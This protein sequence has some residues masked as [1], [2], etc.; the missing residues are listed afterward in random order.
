MIG[1]VAWLDAKLYPGI[2]ANWD[3]RLFR[4]RIS[5]YLQQAPKDV[6][7]LGAGAGI[8]EQMN[9]RGMA[10]RICGL[11]PD[12]RVKTNPFLDEGK[13]GVGESV[14][15]SDESFDVVFADNVLE[16]LREP[17]KVFREVMRVLRPGGV[18]LVKTPN[19]WHYMPLVARLTPHKFHQW[20]NGKRG[21]Q[22][23]DI[24]PTI[25]LANTPKKIRNLAASVGL[26]IRNLDLVESRP[27][28]LRF[29]VPTYIFGWI[30]DLLVNTLP[31]L[32]RF[33]ILIIAELQKPA[34]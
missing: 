22:Q 29:S 28:Y 31:V 6:L 1:S 17:E 16:H 15:Y 18:F 9:F 11:D 8:V 5:R 27:E 21:R 32:G 19:K 13:V 24:F 23:R 12:P 7:D 20:I 26:S 3:D 33:R 2:A 10:N 34:T 25:Y 4:L 30:Y 14:P